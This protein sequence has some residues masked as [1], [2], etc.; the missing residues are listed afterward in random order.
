MGWKQ[1]AAVAVVSGGGILLQ[2]PGHNGMDMDHA[3][4][5]EGAV[6]AEMAAAVGP[7]QTVALEVTGMT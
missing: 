4:M 7:F 3:P 6:P 1:W 5:G 2:I